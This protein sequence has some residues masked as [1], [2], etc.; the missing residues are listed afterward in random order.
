M[1]SRLLTFLM[2]RRFG[3]KSVRRVSALACGFLLTGFLLAACSSLTPESAP[4]EDETLIEVL[5]ELHLIEARASR[6]D[7]EVDPS[8]RDSV[9][10]HYGVTEQ[11][12]EEAL[13]HYAD[14][15]AA[16]ESIYDAVMDSLEAG[17]QHV[18]NPSRDTLPEAPAGASEE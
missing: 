14:R 11:Q 2:P 7:T 8:L 15:P 5:T 18:M 9:F 10:S 1:A 16:Y 17:Q 4:V 3:L 13:E 6:D 12:V